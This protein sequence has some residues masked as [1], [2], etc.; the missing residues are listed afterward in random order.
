MKR[1]LS[2]LLLM[3][4]LS[5]S[6]KG[7]SDGSSDDSTATTPDTTTAPLEDDDTTASEEPEPEPD[8]VTEAPKPVPTVPDLAT[9][10]DTNV[11]LMN[12]T[13]AQRTK[14]NKAVALVKKVVATE[15]FRTQVLNHKWNGSKKFASTTHT[16]TQV[17]N[18]ILEAAEKLTPA[19]NNTMDVGVKLYYENNSVVGWTNTSITYF[20]VNTKFFNSYDIHEVAGNLFHEWLHKLGYGHDSKATTQRPYSVPYA[21]GYIVRDIGKSFL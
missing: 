6:C 12:F 4:L 19:K 17:Y 11:N 8:V 14:Y 13:A 7:G 18:A 21:V 15:K 5:V 3:A 10:W 16:N 1:L 2:L 20:N 9:T